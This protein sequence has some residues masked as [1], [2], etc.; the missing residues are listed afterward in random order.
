MLSE[1]FEAFGRQDWSEETM[2]SSM[3]WSEKQKEVRNSGV[4]RRDIALT[5]ACRRSFYNESDFDVIDYIGETL[6]AKMRDCS[7]E[8]SFKKALSMT[9]EQFNNEPGIRLWYWQA[10]RFEVQIK[11]KLADTTAI[12]RKTESP[13]LVIII[14]RWLE[15]TFSALLNTLPQTIRDES[16]PVGSICD[17]MPQSAIDLVRDCMEDIKHLLPAPRPQSATIGANT[18]FPL[19]QEIRGAEWHDKEVALLREY[20]QKYL[21]GVY[22]SVPEV[23][24]ELQVKLKQWN[25]EHGSLRERTEKNIDDK[26]VQLGLVK[27]H[28]TR[29]VD[30]YYGSAIVDGKRHAGINIVNDEARRL[31]KEGKTGSRQKLAQMLVVTIQT[32]YPGVVLDY[33]DAYLTMF[34]QRGSSDS[35]HDYIDSRADQLQRATGNE[36]NRWIKILTDAPDGESHAAI[37]KRI[38]EDDD[39]RFNNPLVCSEWLPQ[40]CHHGLFLRHPKG[41]SSQ[42]YNLTKSRTNAI[43][44]IVWRRDNVCAMKADNLDYLCLYPNS[45][46]TWK[47]KKFWSQVEVDRLMEVIRNA[48]LD[49]NEVVRWDSKAVKVTAQSVKAGS[50]WTTQLNWAGHAYLSYCYPTGYLIGSARS[51]P[52]VVSKSWE[53]LHASIR[54]PL[55]SWFAQAKQ[56]NLRKR[57][58]TPVHQYCNNDVVLSAMCFAS[59]NLEIP[60]YT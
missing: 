25:A 3:V 41:K 36:Y 42:V 7:A 31:L 48:Y 37:A 19:L 43:A 17:T 57:A 32:R 27:V 54:E 2:I 34:H 14:N 49:R 24:S 15:M 30:E 21:D 60:T 10:V 38:W 44:S 12:L 23:I 26:R 4:L 56:G 8:W 13:L 40:L 1:C 20:W 52:Q 55:N 51:Y 28:L 59:L 47:L 11:V 58:E 22:D 50:V 18:V 39:T 29:R 35:N 53:L 9:L 33:Y 6:N 45:T 46:G 5:L 16:A